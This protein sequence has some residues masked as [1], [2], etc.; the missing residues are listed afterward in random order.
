LKDKADVVHIR[1]DEAVFRQPAEFVLD[2]TGEKISIKASKSAKLRL[3]YGLLRTDWGAGEKL[4]V[5]RPTA[6][7]LSDVAPIGRENQWIEWQAAP[8][9]YEIQRMR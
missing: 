9:E 4:L 8:G 1:L 7:G 6:A 2:W 3:H 5:Q